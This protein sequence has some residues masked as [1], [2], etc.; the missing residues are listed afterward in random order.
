MRRKPSRE[1]SPVLLPEIR[2]R[3]RDGL[4][5]WVGEQREML[6]DPD[7]PVGA[8]PSERVVARK[9]LRVQADRVEE[10]ARDVHRASL[11]WVSRDMTRLAAQAAPGLPPWT[12]LA[13]LPCATGLLAWATPAST[14][15]SVSFGDH[16]EK[17]H[18]ATRTFD[19]ALW[20]LRPEGLWVE[21]LSHV[22]GTPPLTGVLSI[23]IANPDQPRTAEQDIAGTT[24]EEPAPELSI[25]ASAWLLMG[26]P[27]VATVEQRSSVFPTGTKPQ[28]EPDPVTVSIVDLRR[29]E[30]GEAE[31]RERTARRTYHRRWWVDGHWRQ[32]AC[33][34]GRAHRRPV[35]IAPYVKGPDDAPLMQD[36]VRVWRR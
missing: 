21:I 9:A 35:W 2:D 24:E 32:Q 7:H 29:V 8:P 17:L 18:G 16:G 28:A 12:P 36:K 22:G 14:P 11:Y 4:Y 27:K 3:Q 19:A 25:L 23:R 33:G 15:E 1:W 30:H 10:M 31:G 13:A 26:Q 20:T 5:R 34:P 6:T